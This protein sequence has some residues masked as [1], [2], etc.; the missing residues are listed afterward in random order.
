MIDLLTGKVCFDRF[1]FDK[2]TNQDDFKKKYN[3][4]KYE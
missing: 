4:S 2:N 1:V 3:D